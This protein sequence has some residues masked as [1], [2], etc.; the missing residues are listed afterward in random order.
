[1]L[2]NMK[3]TFIKPKIT[4][5]RVPINL[6][7]SGH[8]F[9]FSSELFA[10]EVYAQSSSIYLPYISKSGGIGGRCFT[11]GTLISHLDKTTTPIEKIQLGDI[12]LS[13]DVIKHTF[14]E[15]VVTDIESHTRDDGY[16]LLNKSLKVTHDH[17]LWNIEAWKT[18]EK[19]E[20]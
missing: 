16:Y 5:K 7:F 6:L 11:A 4:V 13:Y 18:V 12:V 1:M 19:I 2:I 3:K 15:G 10:R 9:D 8:G 20:V 14:I 17:P